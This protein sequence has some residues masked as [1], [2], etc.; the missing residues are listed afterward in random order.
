MHSTSDEFFASDSIR[1]RDVSEPISSSDVKRAVI[2][3]GGIFVFDQGVDR[4]EGLHDAGFHILRAGSIKFSIGFADR[5]CF[6]RADVVNGVYVAQNEEA[7]RAFA[8]TPDNVIAC[9]GLFFDLYFGVQSAQLADDDR[10]V[11]IHSRFV[12]GRRFGFDMLG[13]MGDELGVRSV[14]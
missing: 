3:R 10:P 5:I 6:D 12:G 7:A 8:P 13:E 4:G 14:K 11:T 2:G 9:F 1:V